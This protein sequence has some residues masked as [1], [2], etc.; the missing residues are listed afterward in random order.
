MM[1]IGEIDQAIQTVELIN[2]PEAKVE[3]LSL[4]ALEL[5]IN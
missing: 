5:M 3:L 4:L 1:T 2:N